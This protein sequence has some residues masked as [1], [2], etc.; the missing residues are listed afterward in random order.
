M[1]TVGTTDLVEPTWEQEASVAVKQAELFS[2]VQQRSQYL[3]NNQT[4]GVLCV[5]YAKTRS[6]RHLVKISAF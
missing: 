4:V 1:I 5:E 2:A 6:R 3:L